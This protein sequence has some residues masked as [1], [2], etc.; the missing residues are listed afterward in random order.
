MPHSAIQVKMTKDGEIRPFRSLYSAPGCT[1]YMLHDGHGLVKKFYDIADSL[2]EESYFICNYSQCVTDHR[3]K[4][5]A[6]EWSPLVHESYSESFVQHHVLFLMNS[7]E[8]RYTFKRNFPKWHVELVNNCLTLSENTFSITADQERIYRAVYNAKPAMFK[9]HHLA[10]KVKDLALISY[11]EHRL[12]GT[13]SFYNIR[14]MPHSAIFWG[15]PEGAV[16]EVLNSSHCGL[17]L[18][19]QEGACYASAEYLLCGLPVVS[20]RSRGGRSE[21]YTELNSIICEDD[22]GSVAAAVTAWLERLRNDGVDRQEIRVQAIRQQEMYRKRLAAALERMTGLSS[23]DMF[24]Y[25]TRSIHSDPKLLN[26][27]Q[28]WMGDWNLIAQKQDAEAS[29][30]PAK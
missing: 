14:E 18:S 24:E 15:V 9:R 16:C 4:E 10:L 27:C 20:T 6:S 3:C 29:T 11:S 2:L 21:Y 19:A 13:P 7:E 1:I 28:Y 17:I 22:A 23:A 25:L 26:K 5:I 30:I 12:V 8:E